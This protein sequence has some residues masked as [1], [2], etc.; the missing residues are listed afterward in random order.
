MPR[1]DAVH[2]PGFLHVAVEDVGQR[3]F[4][5]ALKIQ[6]VKHCLVTIAADE[7]ERLAVRRG[8][9]RIDPP[10]PVT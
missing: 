9:G 10:G 2:R 4:A 1:I 8:V 3:R 7:R 6:V 5:P